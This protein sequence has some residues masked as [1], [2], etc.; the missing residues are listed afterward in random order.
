MPQL[1]DKNG[2]AAFMW[3]E[4]E[5][6]NPLTFECEKTI[7]TSQCDNGAWN[8]AIGP[9]QKTN[10]YISE[11][12]GT[13]SKQNGTYQAFFVGIDE[14]Q[15]TKLYYM[16]RSNNDGMK[17]LT[18]GNHI[19][20]G[21]QPISYTVTNNSE[22]TLKSFELKV[23][24]DDGTIL[25]KEVSCNLLPG[26]SAFFEDTFTFDNL[27][28]IENFTV[29][30]VADG[31]TD[32]TNTQLKKEVSYCDL[33]ISDVKKEIVKDGVKYTVTIKNEGQIDTSG[34]LN[35]YADNQ[36]SKKLETTEIKTVKAGE[37]REISVQYNTKDM[38]FDA[39]QNAYCSMQVTA[40]DKDSNDQNDFYYGVVYRWELPGQNNISDC[41]VLLESDRYTPDGT[42]KTPEVTVKR[43][44]LLLGKRYRL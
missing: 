6:K 30:T 11:L 22:E 1:M 12:K 28:K 16:N 27:S 20:K 14:E 41:T 24:N 43:G 13:Y 9:L 19:F 15:K 5:L 4:M 2:N 44:D 10:A 8:I 40:N 33:A 42:A 29:Q 17:Q 25:Q 35:I 21:K 34:N 36:L 32:T 23:S 31:Q 18:D 38:K 39:S 26:E 7:M 3:I 37:I